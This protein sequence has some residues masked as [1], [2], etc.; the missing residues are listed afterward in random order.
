MYTI[1]LNI[2]PLAVAVFEGIQGTLGLLNSYARRYP[3][4]YAGYLQS[5]QDRHSNADKR[6]GCYDD[7]GLFSCS[8][9]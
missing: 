6:D 3:R 2:T 8:A 4:T 5:Q 9:H 7:A 1:N